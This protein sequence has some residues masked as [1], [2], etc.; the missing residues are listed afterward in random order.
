MFDVQ[1]CTALPVRPKGGE[2]MDRRRKRRVPFRRSP[3]FKA[4]SA[5]LCVLLPPAG[6][7]L[8]WKSGWRGASRYGRTALAVGVCVLLVAL[9]PLGGGTSRGGVEMV[10]RQRDTEV[11]GPEKPESMVSG[12]MAPAEDSVLSTATDAPEEYVYARE[13][14]T[15]YHTASCKHV[16]GDSMKMTV[17]EAYY[18]GFKPCPDCDPEQYVIEA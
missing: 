13:G 2:R 1:I 15:Y 3:V 18:G 9:I 17:Y 8:V 14:E 7:W 10:G 12:Y 5:L 4:L 6:I 11:Y 16:R